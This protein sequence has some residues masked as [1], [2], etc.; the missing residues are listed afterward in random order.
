[1]LK[2]KETT[3][4]E[5]EKRILEE[6]Y[7]AYVT[8]AGWIGRHQKQVHG[9]IEQFLGYSDEKIKRLSKEAVAQ[10]F[11]HFKVRYLIYLS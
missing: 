9:L 5:R 10:G 2:A 1:M 3:K 11:N 8:S 7:P 4:A 6:G